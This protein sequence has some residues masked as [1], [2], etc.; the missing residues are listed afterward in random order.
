VVAQCR[1]ADAQ[2]AE[3]LM[4]EQID[5]PEPS[6]RPDVRRASFEQVRPKTI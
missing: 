6:R 1:R 5:L 3:K 4:P 2:T